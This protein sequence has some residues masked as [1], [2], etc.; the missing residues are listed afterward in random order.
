MTP[1]GK[2]ALREASAWRHAAGTVVDVRL[3]SGKVLRTRTRSEATV[4]CDTAVIWVDGISGCYALERVTV[5]MG[6]A[7]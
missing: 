6:G 3:D 1:R 7:R 4:V 5:A 2:R